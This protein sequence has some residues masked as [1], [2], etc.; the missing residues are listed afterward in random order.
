MSW[1]SRLARAFRSSGLDRALDEEMAFHIE[2]RIADLVAD[3][4]TRDAADAAARRQ[5]G[6]RLRLREESRDIKLLPWLDSLARDVRLGARML[7]KN[8]L[9]TAAAVV[10]LGLALGASVAAFSLVDALILKPLPVHEPERL[11]Y[12]TYP[13]SNPDMPEDDVFSDPAFVRLRDAGRGHVDLFA[14]TYPN[15]PRV[16]FEDAHGE[17]ETIRTQFVSGDAF[18]RLGIGPSQGR[19]LTMQDDERPGAHPVAV[20]SHAFWMQ[21]FGGDPGIVGRWFTV[22]GSKTIV[23]FRSS[24]SRSR[25]SAE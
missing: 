20:L 12:L 14:I 10:S 21:R 2:S 24:A 23:C 16:T 15:K 22:H 17:R 6:N 1:L 25:A 11:I 7:R 18:E 19:L 5:F 13:S 8:G 3:G 9:V 4:M